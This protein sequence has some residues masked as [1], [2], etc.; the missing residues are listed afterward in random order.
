MPLTSYM[1]LNVNV[2]VNVDMFFTLSCE[3][4]GRLPNLKRWK[5]FTV[6]MPGGVEWGGR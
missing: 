5:F 6:H 4:V 1:M 3:L 2:K